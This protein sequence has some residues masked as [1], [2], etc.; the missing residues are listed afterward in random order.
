MLWWKVRRL[1]SSSI[2]TRKET[3]R[4]LGASGETGAVPA[5]VAALQDEAAEVRRTAAAALAQLGHPAAAEPLCAALAR[6]CSRSAGRRADAGDTAEPGELATAV[7]A[8]GSHAVAPLLHLLADEGKDVRR[9]AAH[10]LGLAGDA[11]ARDPLIARLADSRSEVRREA[12]LALGRLRDD[13]ALAPLVTALANKDA[14]TRRA[15]AE[16]LGHLGSRE[17]VDALVR[18][19][20]D[21]SEPIQLAAVGALGR[22]GGAP[23]AAGLRKVIDAT[24]RKSVREAA[25]AA[26][27]AMRIESSEPADRARFAV[28]AGRFDAAV[29]QGAVAVPA[30]IEA[31]GSR[32]P[33]RRGQAARCLGELSAPEAAG[34]LAQALCDLDRTVAAAASRSLVRVGLG[35]LPH[36]HGALAGSDASAQRLAAEAIGEIGDP[37]SVG[38]LSGAISANRE[39]TTDYPDTHDAARAA[40]DALTRILGQSAGACL[41]ADLRLAAEVPD[42]VLRRPGSH[43]APH[44]SRV[45][46]AAARDLARKELQR[47]GE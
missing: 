29:A 6:A 12:A 39:A 19:A 10:A 42:A 7:A 8:L 34:T 20:E 25:A 46:C 43:A 31:L 35:A 1:K 41:T 21:P 11:A 18:A 15:A 45:D 28:L 36:L 9:W 3:A 27:A 4:S 14:D 38:A 13:A 16:A 30:L 32:D 37:G 47:R 5:L 44:E 33:L 22:I 40:S 24:P 26:F 23:A 2:Q 17:A